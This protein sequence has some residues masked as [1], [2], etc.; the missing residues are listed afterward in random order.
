MYSCISLFDTEYSSQDRSCIAAG[1]PTARST[2]VAAR[3]KPPLPKMLRLLP[4]LALSA[5][6]SAG[7]PTADQYI[8]QADDRDA[9]EIPQVQYYRQERVHRPFHT[10]P[11]H[12]LG[13]Q[14]AFAPCRTSQLASTGAPLLR[15]AS[16]R[17]GSRTGGVR[18][19]YHVRRMKAQ[20]R[21]QQRYAEKDQPRRGL[22]CN[23]AGVRM[24]CRW[25]LPGGCDAQVQKHS[26]TVSKPPPSSG[27]GRLHIGHAMR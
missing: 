1:R 2:A 9:S 7:G 6:A 16:H 13:A 22:P 14:R 18:P 11:P 8:K 19:F 27:G 12:I 10:R 3:Q 26:S 4:A 17:H 20:P 21:V 24:V 5:L 15:A 25:V 23:V